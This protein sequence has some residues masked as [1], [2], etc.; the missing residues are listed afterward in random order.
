MARFAAAQEL[1]TLSVPKAPLELRGF[2]SFFIDGTTHFLNTPIAMVAGNSMIN[3]MY[4]QFQRP[5]RQNTQWPIVFVHGSWTTSKIWETTPD[6]R[7][8]WYEYFTRQGYDTYLADQVGAGRSG[9]DASILNKVRNGLA[10]AASNPHMGIPTI[11]FAWDVFRFGDFKT[12]TPYP[13]EQFPMETT[14]YGAGS[15]LDFYKQLVP[16]LIGTL[17]GARPGCQGTA[18]TPLDPT[19]AWSTPAAMAKLADQLGGAILVGHAEASPFPTMAALQ[20]GAHP[21]NIKAL[22]QLETGCF[23]RLTTASI[24]TLKRIPLLILVGD[25]F[26]SQPTETC[27]S[28]MNQLKSAGGDISFISLPALGIHGNSRLMMEDRNNLQV[29]D[30]ILEWIGRHVRDRDGKLLDRSAIP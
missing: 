1:R 23:D 29:A 20:A 14:G 11:Q 25:H 27:R 18:C 19:K 10:A 30:V 15:T 13:D 16:D 6:G 8:G 17:P 7:M 5:A 21:Q 2:G 28:E 9:F 24:G 22:I 4:V 26:G 12:F 3:Q